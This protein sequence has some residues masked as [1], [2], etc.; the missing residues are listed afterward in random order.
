MAGSTDELSADDR[1]GRG[2]PRSPS[3]GVRV[4]AFRRREGQ[5]RPGGDP[6]LS[7]P[8]TR[9]IV[10]LA[11]A[12]SLAAAGSA[13]SEDEKPKA[14]APEKD[15]PRTAAEEKAARLAAVEAELAR[16]LGGLKTLRATFVQR[17]RLEVFEEEVK[18]SG[19]LAL[20]VPG[21]LRWEVASPVKTVLV[22]NGDRGLRVRTSRK[23]AKTETRFLLEDDPVAA[24]TAQQIFL[25]LRGDL[26][27]ARKGYDLEILAETPLRIR[28]V[29]RAAET[30][31]VLAAVEI[32]FAEDRKSVL[33]VTLEEAPDTRAVITFSDVERDP[34]LAKDLF[35]IG[36]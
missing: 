9:L 20:A 11:A 15:P 27:A 5:L 7:F 25:W 2:D 30:R 16:N 21:R 24:G 28:A 1:H 3:R 12:V 10:L 35:E 6:R 33:E 18:S 14:A 29:P 22:V 19:S 36:K 31:K 32:R 34:D 23:G 26:E 13:R 17:K 4:P 8:R